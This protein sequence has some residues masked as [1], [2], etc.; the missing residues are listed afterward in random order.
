MFEAR[1]I[2][3][4]GPGW[5]ALERDLALAACETVWKVEDVTGMDV[6]QRL[7]IRLLT[8]GGLAAA[9]RAHMRRMMDRLPQLSDPDS[10]RHSGQ[11]RVMR[12]VQPW[13]MSAIVSLTWPCLGGQFIADPDGMYGQVLM[14]PRALKAGR[15]TD[16]QL[17]LIVAHEATHQAQHRAGP[18]LM[19][20]LLERAVQALTDRM[21]GRVA[22]T[23]HRPLTEGHA[24]WTHRRVAQELYGYPARRSFGDEPLP[25]LRPLL[26]SR[27]FGRL[28]ML[29]DKQADY[30][31]GEKFINDVLAKG[32]DDQLERV[33]T[34][35]EMMPF[36]R[37]L[38]D[39]DAWM[40][41]V[42]RVA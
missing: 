33:W 19:P 39:V 3:E 4:V 38:T 11:L 34:S 32:G 10:D 36:A 41:R 21:D 18:G 29:R 8:P 12:A 2:N 22:A 14:V 35:V 20:Q 5:E 31:A 13:V 9:N 6:G 30:D 37:E 24:Q 42:K 25:G 23:L 16:K 15:T 7:T 40:E 27:V 26:T 28:P 17:R 1:I